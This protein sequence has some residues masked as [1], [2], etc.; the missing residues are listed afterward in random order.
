MMKLSKSTGTS[1]LLAAIGLV[2]M[3]IYLLLC[4]KFG[5]KSDA[6]SKCKPMGKNAPEYE[7]VKDLLTREF[8]DL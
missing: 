3:S 1:L 5:N 4:T 6:D 2:C 7:K 8:Y